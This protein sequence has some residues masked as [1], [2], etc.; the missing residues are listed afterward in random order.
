[1]ETKSCCDHPSPGS[2]HT[3]DHENEQKPAEGHK[4]IDPVCG[5]TV[6]PKVARGGSST[7]QGQDYYFC[8]PKCKQKFDADPVR[9]VQPKPVVSVAVDPVCGM[10]V[11]PKVARGGSSTYQGQDYYFC[12]PKCKQKFDADPERYVQ[13]KSVV[14]VA[15]KVKN[16][17]EYTCPMHPEIRQLGPGSCPLCGMALEPVEISLEYEE[18]TTEYDDMKR[19]LL[20]SALLS[21]PLVVFTM[22]FRH[23][24]LGSSSSAAFNWVEVVLATPVVCWGGWPFFVR[25]YQSLANRSLNMFTLI[26]IGV[27]TAYGYSLIA[28]LFPGLF[29][30]S[31]RDGSGQI[32]LYFEAAAVIVTL[33]LLGQ[34]LELRA[35][36]QTGGAIRALLGLAPKTARKI[37]PDGQEI[38][39]D[40]KEIVVGDRFRVR[41]GEKIPVDGRVVSGQSAVDESMI[42]GE[43]IPVEK[44]VG[45]KVFGATLNGLGTLVITAEKV[46]RDTLLSQIVQM[47]SDAQRSR[48]PI[49]RLAD[50]VS[51]YFVPAVVATSVLSFVV[52]G[53]W[54]PEPAMA[55]ALLNAIAVL[56]IACPC[57]LG[58]ATPMSIMVASGKAAGLGVLFKNAEAIETL[59]KVDTLVVDKTGTL[60]E[61]KPQ[62]AAVVSLDSAFSEDDVLKIAASLETGSEHPLASAIVAGAKTRGIPVEVVHQFRSW[63]GRGVEGRLA[64]TTLFLGNK[65]LF[66]EKSIPI[67]RAETLAEEWQR[68]GRTVMFVGDQQHLIGLVGVADPIKESAKETIETLRSQGIRVVMLTGDSQK[69]ASAV[70]QQLQLDEVIAEVLPDQK[71]A[72][73]QRFQKEGRIVAMAGDGINDAPALAVAHVGIA[74]GTGTD[75]AIHSAGVTLVKGDLRGILRARKISE[76]TITNIKQNLFFAF[77]YNA[78]GV[79]IAAGVMYPFF[80]LLLSPTIAAAAMSLSSVSVIANALRLRSQ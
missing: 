9:Y 4:T 25:F 39:V 72:V 18:D 80:G 53:V 27:G 43:P 10:T 49:Q 71:S 20:W 44:T 21:V 77:V 35:R 52:W 59:R 22:G 33:V 75:V 69:T 8:N 14:P 40:V 5:M 58:L 32:G 2:V 50:V 70:A 63:T 62:L 42:S 38:D 45:D 37:F 51:G 48:A 6:D 55:M 16:D 54:G 29:P 15:L 46:G 28:V 61:G 23:V 19:R 11:D 36:S 68:L 12:N 60:T 30:E 78:V 57:A 65:T 79:P 74:M 73:L 31:F 3:H 13:P 76:L 66:A 47:V 56:I 26:G 41:P 7:Y 67:D 1:M 34:V 64:G 24:I 17:V